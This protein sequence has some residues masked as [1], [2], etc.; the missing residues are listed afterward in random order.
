MLVAIL[1]TGACTGGSGVPEGAPPTDF[2]TPLPPAEATAQKP[3]APRTGWQSE[4]PFA[5]QSP[6]DQAWPGPV[7]TVRVFFTPESS[8]SCADVTP[9]KREVRK[10]RAVATAALKQLFKGPTAEEEARGLLSFFGPATAGLLRSIRV[11]SG[12]AYVDINDITRINNLSTSCGSTIFLSQM[13]ATLKQFPTVTQV[14]YAMEGDPGSF[15]ASLQ[16]GC[17]ELLLD[18]QGDCV[19]GPF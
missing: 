7:Q 15:Y 6:S 2:Q 9:V 3:E 17:P 16:H 11:E 14:V 8:P 18:Q 4:I 1:A 13:D 19:W 5:T 12:V 10:T